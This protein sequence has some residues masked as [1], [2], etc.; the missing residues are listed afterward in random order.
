MIDKMLR[1]REAELQKYA[2]LQRK[3]HAAEKIEIC[4]RIRVHHF[5]FTLSFFKKFLQKKINLKFVVFRRYIKRSRRRRSS[6]SI[7]DKNLVQK[8]EAEN[9][10][11]MYE[12]PSLVYNR[13]STNI[14]KYRY[15]H[16]LDDET[17]ALYMQQL[18]RQLSRLERFRQVS[19]GPF[20]VARHQN[21]PQVSWFFR[22][23]S[24]PSLT[25]PTSTNTTNTTTTITSSTTQTN[26][27]EQPSLRYSK[28]KQNNHHNK[29]KNH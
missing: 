6:A 14:L 28:R 29:K 23:R 2:D 7:D 12:N 16:K 22:R 5:I 1:N 18:R 10:E 19:F 13:L 17:L 11:P 4:R 3:L 8:I 9:E 24:L 27:Y 21:D 15:L 26:I 25:D 20:S